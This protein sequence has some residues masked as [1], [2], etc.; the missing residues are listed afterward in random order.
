[1]TF[2]NLSLRKQL[3]SIKHEIDLYPKWMYYVKTN[4][5]YERIAHFDRKKRASRAFYKMIEML[6]DGVIN[7][8]NPK[9]ALCLCE[10]PGGFV[11]AL[12]F[13]YP[14]IFIYAQSLGESIRFDN[15][16]DCDYEY[17]DLTKLGSILGIIRKFKTKKFDIITADGG[18]D[19][20]DDYSKQEERSMRI[21]FVQVL[22]M[23]YCL[24]VGGTFVIKI[25]DCFE[26]E[27]V[28]ILQL[29]Y[30]NFETINI[31]KPVLSRPCNSEKYVVCEKFKGYNKYNNLIRQVESKD[32]KLDIPISLEFRDKI[33]EYNTKY[34]NRQIRNITEILD[35]CKGKF[36]SKNINNNQYLKSK[37]MFN[38]L[39]LK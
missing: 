25:F 36:N 2:I 33:L 8:N 23:L 12:Q 31:H 26:K 11:Q 15:D 34:V 21:I 13:M 9:R 20:S 24:N 32:I 14:G 27:T 39:K 28:Q 29:L 19:V 37:E 1:M 6:R 22:T 3:N 38:K 7:C 16:L 30:C 35:S 5:E 4:F 10:A 17:S 18:I